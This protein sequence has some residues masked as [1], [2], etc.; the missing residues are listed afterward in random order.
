MEENKLNAALLE[1]K[2]QNAL[3]TMTSVD[4]EY[5]YKEAAARFA[6]IRDYKDSET[7]ARECLEKAEIARK[8]AILASGNFKMTGE[9]VSY[10]ESALEMFE[11]IPGWKDADERAE[12]CRQTIARLNKQAEESRA[13]QLRLAEER[14]RLEERRLRRKKILLR[15]LLWV[16]LPALCVLIAAPIVR[17]KIL[18][19]NEKYNEAQRL[20][21]AGQREDALAIF[22]EIGKFRDAR[23]RAGELRLQ[24]LKETLQT[25]ELGESVFFGTYE[26]DWESINGKEPIE[27]TVMDRQDGR[28]L[29]LSKAGLDSVPYHNEA[30][31]VTWETSNVREW[32]NTR[33]F[34]NAFSEIEQAVISTV[35]VTDSNNPE[36]DTPSGND[37]QDKVFLLSIDE[38]LHYFP[39][40]SERLA[41]RTKYAKGQGVF[42]R[43]K[44][45]SCWWWLRSPGKEAGY[46]CSVFTAGEI[47]IHGNSVELDYM[48]VRPAIWIDLNA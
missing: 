18:I 45:I 5:A 36:Y 9:I 25:L 10:Y 2:Y 35:T 48:A 32:L 28:V 7:L 33:F 37:T 41:P 24:N 31:P 43:G 1:I 22:T 47:L 12:V 6:E 38:V 15:F 11:M 30:A 40:E 23:E 16:V 29:L 26:Q 27:W 17:D 46:A 42:A 20:L 13:L 44:P 4:A 34:Q 3:R 14:N 19:P 8:D 39:E 21:E